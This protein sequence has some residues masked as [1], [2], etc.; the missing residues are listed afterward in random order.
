MHVR[1]FEADTL[2]EALKD[3]K[4]QLGPDAIILKTITNKGLKGAF[5]K[6]K[7]EITAAI[8]ERSYVKKDRVDQV[9]S[10]EQKEQF[11][12]NDSSYISNMIDGHSENQKLEKSMSSTVGYGKAGLNKQ[13]NSVAT[14]A[15]DL[16]SK[17]KSS[18]DDF[19]SHEQESEINEQ[20]QMSLDS[21]EDAMMEETSVPHQYEEPRRVSNDYVEMHN[22]QHSNVS[23]EEIEVQKKKIDELEKQLY[24]LTKNVEKL[25][26]KEAS[27]IYQLRTTLKSLDISDNFIRS[28]IKKATFELSEEDQ[29][30]PDIVFEFALREMLGEV[31][32]AMPLFSS[33]TEENAPVVT[34]MISDSSCGQTS[35]VQKL[36]ALKSD[37]VIIRNLKVG[38]KKGPDFTEKMFGIDVVTVDSIAEIV[39]QTRKSVENGKSVFIDYKNMNSDLNDIKKFIDGMRRAF[40]NVEVLITLSAIHSEIYNRKVISRYGSLANGMIVSNLDLCLNFGALFNLSIE[41][42]NLPF[43]FFGTGEVVP[44]D[45]ESATA[46]RVLA[47]IF[48]LN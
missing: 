46:E 40:K 24:A 25:E 43:K 2:D 8:S 48:Q 28:I 35:M 27:G 32:T 7:I 45:I 29:D 11:Y 33:L 18:L 22:N 30:N 19:L 6:K 36:G 16:S 17:L 3:I 4:A 26:K 5:K 20:E 23:N 14:K 42:E 1:K 12:S 38:E 34:V 31:E 15:K 44:D 37:A 21:F 9:L 10:S 13:V 47:G 39:S 41:V